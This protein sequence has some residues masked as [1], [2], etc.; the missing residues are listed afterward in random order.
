MVRRAEV[1]HYH[2][3]LRPIDVIL[4]LGSVGYNYEGTNQIGVLQPLGNG[5]TADTE[6]L[7]D[8]YSRKSRV[9]VANGQ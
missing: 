7:F 6:T 9:T 3:R 4:P 1:T 2:P 8:S 5:A